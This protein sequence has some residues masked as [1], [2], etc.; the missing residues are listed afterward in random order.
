M[1]KILQV[2][3]YPNPTL[4]QK[5][6]KIVSFDKNLKKFS[7][8]MLKTVEHYKGIGLAAPQVGV[9]K[10]IFVMRLEDE[11]S[12][13]IQSHICINP[14]IKDVQGEMDF[15]EACLSI[16]SVQ[17]KVTR[18]AKLTLHY[19]DLEGNQKKLKAEKLT[20]ICIQ[21]E[22]DHLDGI[23][24]IYRISPLKRRLLLSKYKKNIEKR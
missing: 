16:P 9:L 24:F 14:E 18:K 7:Q 1:E 22:V 10:R 3:F 5:S 2:L 4:L 13:E 6:E 8:D 11:T 23:L 21:H 15:E 19:Q 20:A 12:K 17:E